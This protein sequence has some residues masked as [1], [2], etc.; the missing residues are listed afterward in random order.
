MP[1]QLS[2]PASDEQKYQIHARY[3]FAIQQIA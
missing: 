3:S 1:E 2:D